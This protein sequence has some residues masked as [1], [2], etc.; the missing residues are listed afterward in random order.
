MSVSQESDLD[1]LFNLEQ[2]YD[3]SQ[4]LEGYKCGLELGEKD[5]RD[6]GYSAGLEHGREKGSE[7]GYYYGVVSVWIQ[8][9]QSDSSRETQK[10]NVQILHKL[11][12]LL[13]MIVEFPHGNNEIV[14]ERLVNIRF[15]IRQVVSMLRL[16]AANYMYI[17]DK[18]KS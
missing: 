7:I 8:L 15:K 2:H 6:Q 18:R 3:E 14:D 5:G 9:L 11:Q 12:L 10:L 1:D 13:K 17:S 4:E 16:D